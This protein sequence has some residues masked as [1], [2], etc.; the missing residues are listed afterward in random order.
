MTQRLFSIT[1][2]ITLLCIL[3]CVGC[4]QVEQQSKLTAA[5][6]ARRAAKNDRTTLRADPKALRKQLGANEMAKFLVE[7]NDVVEANLFRS[8]LRSVEPLKGLPLRGLDLGF[9]YV[10]DLSPLSGMPLES[11]VLENTSVAD[12]SPLKG[13]PLKVLKIQNT[14]V[15]DFSFLDGMRL[16]HFNVLNLP[17]SDLHA[18]RDMPLNTLWLTGSKV[19]DLTA[20]SGSR[21][22]SLDIERTEVSDLSSL[23]TMSGL[24]RL[25]IAATPVTDLSPLA[26]LSLERIVL[27][28]ERIHTGID[29]IRKMKSLV[30]IQ[31]SV[32]Q[33]LTADEFWKRFDLGIWDDSRQSSET[34]PNSPEVTPAAAETTSSEPEIK[35]P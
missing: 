17:F 1:A 19:T 15:T 8:G 31:T 33:N 12:L 3:T 22:V 29:A 13:M 9:T 4:G 28:P 6:Q 24:K 10:S 32:D 35:T 25:N 18:V 5:E 7:G 11:L 23:A 27:S 21:I 34:V 16:T 26:N 2:Q 30:Y 20:L 14:K